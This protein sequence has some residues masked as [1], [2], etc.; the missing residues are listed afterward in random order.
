MSR[1]DVYRRF[2]E[3]APNRGNLDVVEDVF[4]P[5]V[6]YYLPFS[7]EP[8][9][10]R[11]AVKEVVSGFRTAFPDLKVRVEELIEE[12]D[13]LA[14][15]VTASGTNGGELMGNPPTGRKA[16]WSVV[17][18]CHFREGR[19]AE[20]RITFDVLAFMQQLGVVPAPAAV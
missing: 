14:A 18:I 3:E 2:I 10:G 4:T 16:T 9:V 6:K 11:E 13:T 15:R 8:L 17:H 7:P 5:D 20:D 1:K 19:I 12:G